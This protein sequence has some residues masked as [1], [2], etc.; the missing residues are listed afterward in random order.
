[1]NKHTLFET[2]KEEISQIVD[3]GW[4]YHA[5]IF[6][7]VVI[8]TYGLLG[9]MEM[10]IRKMIS[11][12]KAEKHEEKIGEI[13]VRIKVLEGTEEKQSSEENKNT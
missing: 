4:G 10:R 1:M 9:Y 3:N 12:L 6:L 13:R 7:F 11:E 8:T 2:F 5:I